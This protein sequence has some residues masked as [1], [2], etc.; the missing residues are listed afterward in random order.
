MS[1]TIFPTT[2]SLNQGGTVT[3]LAAGGTGPY[4]FSM[5]SGNG[6][7]DAST[8]VYLASAITGLET[9]MLTDALLATASAVIT[10]NSA[11]TLFCDIIRQEMG[12]GIDQVWIYN[13]K[14]DIPTDYRLYV[15]IEILSCKPFANTRYMDPSGPG[16]NQILST[17]FKAVLSVNILS[18]GPAARDRKE[19]FVL[20]LNSIYSIQQ[21]EANGFMVSLLP[22]GFVNLSEIDGSAIPYRFNISVAVQY[23]IVKTEAVPYYSTFP[24]AQV[25]QIE[26]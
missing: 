10:V 26:P 5:V 13:Q 18:R 14:I 15:A 7:V 2:V 6:T 8:G 3:F 17:N 20:A 11:L 1:L 21:Q 23:K 24:A 16:L 19:E 9:V 25:A 4:V 22:S 12:L